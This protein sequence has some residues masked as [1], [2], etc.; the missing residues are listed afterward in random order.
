MVN[1]VVEDFVAFDDLKTKG[2]FRLHTLRGAEAADVQCGGY[3]E[4]C[5]L[6]AAGLKLGDMARKGHDS[7]EQYGG[8]MVTAKNVRSHMA[9]QFTALPDFFREFQPAP[10]TQ[11][12]TP[13]RAGTHGRSRGEP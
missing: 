4:T 8:M 9:G 10:G 13:A 5:K 3:I 12:W 7:K 6:R 1:V 11:V 2:G